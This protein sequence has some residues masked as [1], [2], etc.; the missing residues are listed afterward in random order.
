MKETE[1]ILN[2]S[3]GRNDDTVYFY[4]DSHLFARI[5]DCDT[6]EVKITRLMHDSR[7]NLVFPGEMTPPFWLFFRMP[8]CLEHKAWDYCI[9][10]SIYV[11]VCW[12]GFSVFGNTALLLSS[13]ICISVGAL[14]R[15]KKESIVSMMSWKFPTP[16]QLSV[17]RDKNKTHLTVTDDDDDDD[18][19]FLFVL[20]LCLLMRYFATMCIMSEPAW[21]FFLLL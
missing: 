5:L 20:F 4:E 14:F 1:H 17:Q 13:Y 9:A 18:A 12:C 19:S 15:D 11:P 8:S 21:L 16:K 3:C 2:I 7:Q 6:F 10:T